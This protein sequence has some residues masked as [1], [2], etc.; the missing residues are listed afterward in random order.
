MG[1]RVKIS[2]KFLKGLCLLTAYYISE[3]P[4]DLVELVQPNTSV[5][6]PRL[7]DGTIVELKNLRRV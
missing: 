5:N 4:E 3:G 6:S 7:M 2:I 1:L